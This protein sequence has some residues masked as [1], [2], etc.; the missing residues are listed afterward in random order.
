MAT[1]SEKTLDFAPVDYDIHAMPPPAPEGEWVARI[2]EVKIQPTAKGNFPMLIVEWSLEGTDEDEHQ[3]FIGATIPDFVVFFPP[4]H[5][6][7]RMGKLRMRALC[8]KVGIDF[9]MVPTKIANKSDLEE[10][11]NALKDTDKVTVWTRVSKDSNNEDRTSIVYSKP[12]VVSAASDD[13][14]EDEKPAAKKS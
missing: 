1:N 4:N 13:E 2:G 9:D 12:G 14:D 5:K 8:E 3:S 10:F 7:A 11:V 6:G